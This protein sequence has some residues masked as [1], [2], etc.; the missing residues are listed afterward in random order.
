MDSRSYF[1][2]LYGWDVENYLTEGIRYCAI[3]IKLTES[4]SDNLLIQYGNGIRRRVA[5]MFLFTDLDDAIAW[6][7]ERKQSEI[8][9]ID[10][11]I[12]RLNAAKETIYQTYANI[13]IE[14][15]VI[16]SI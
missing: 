8:D 2:I 7:H 5:G 6:V 14:E 11:Q 1:R 13:N 3:Y 9:A 10:S 16:F 15:K 12:Y 4:L